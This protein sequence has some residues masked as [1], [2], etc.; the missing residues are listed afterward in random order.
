M[1]TSPSYHGNF[2]DRDQP[3]LN[4]VADYIADARTL[5]QDKIPPY[6]YDDPSLLVA[7]NVTMLEAS[8]LRADLFV[9]NLGAKGQVQAFRAVD[10]T[11]VAI[12][13]PFRLAVLHGL[14]GHAIE[15]DQE[16]YQDARATIFLGLFSTGLVGRSLPGVAGGS[17]P[18]GRP[19][20]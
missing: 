9:W 2:S 7:L 12:E 3:T 13:P 17:P 14:C 1:A 8:R 5:L 11:H 20:Q 15:R 6:R 18:A 4:T 19:Q 10:D 16:D